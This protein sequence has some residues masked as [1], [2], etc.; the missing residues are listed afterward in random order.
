LLNSVNDEFKDLS[1][2]DLMH[3]GER[4]WNLKRVINNRFGL[5]R[6]ND[7]L[8]KAF[9][10]PFQDNPDGAAGYIPDFPAMIEEYYRVRAWD[11]QTG[12][13]LPEKLIEL[14]LEWTINDIWS[15]RSNTN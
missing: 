7:R 15:N 9:Q 10:K 2:D 14:G 5:T 1:L 12:Y 4:G 13:P 3:S 6:K 8:P 11:K